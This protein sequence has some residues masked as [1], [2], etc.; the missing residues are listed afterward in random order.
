MNIE[1]QNSHNAKD[2]VAAT[3]NLAS[4]MAVD[5]QPIIGQQE[6][7]INSNAKSLN[8]FREKFKELYDNA[9]EKFREDI[10]LE[11]LVDYYFRHSGIR[12]EDQEK[13]ELQKLTKHMSR[14]NRNDNTTS[15]KDRI[16]KYIPDYKRYKESDLIT[17]D[18]QVYL[19][20]VY[21]AKGLEFDN[22]I[23]AEAVEGTY[24]HWASKPE[25][26]KRED[27]RALYVALSRAKKRLYV[28]SHTISVNQYGK[29]FPKS[30][31]PY[32]RCIQHHFEIIS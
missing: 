30:P 4:R 6:Q 1:G 2:D 17:G 21:K 27:A 22:V 8:R 9:I 19:S 29:I 13:A 10:L 14:N 16:N 24:P 12:M 32:L 25:D 5:V 15:L 31:S 7:L 20:T 3:A 23:V 26:Q 11:D 18:E 28:T